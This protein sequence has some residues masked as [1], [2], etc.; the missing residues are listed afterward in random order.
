V[1]TK[2]IG[3]ILVTEEVR[4]IGTAAAVREVDLVVLAASWDPRSVTLSRNL[5]K[6]KNGLRVVF[7][8]GEGNSS[9]IANRSKVLEALS[10]VC[11][12]VLTLECDSFGIEAFWVQLT[13]HLEHLCGELGRRISV[14]VDVSCLP[15]FIPAALI[16]HPLRRGEL[17]SAL[18][19]EYA[20]AVSYSFPNGE[21]SRFAAGSW[22][23]IV[24]PGAYGRFKPDSL[25]ML[26]VSTGFD[27]SSTYKSVA[28][29]EPQR[30]VLVMPVGGSSK[31]NDERARKSSTAL[32]RIPGSSTITALAFSP[33]DVCEKLEEIDVGEFEVLLLP[34]GTKLQ[35]VGFALFVL[36]KQSPV[37]LYRRPTRHVEVHSESN[38]RS[39]ITSLV[40]T[41]AISLR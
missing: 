6:A 26:V 4:V 25:R 24:V 34:S 13:D 3:P 10:E 21:E 14:Y 2:T 19:L 33:L 12:S 38:G 28:E 39:V 18:H 16:C 7:S 17:I 29:L 22:H 9:S 31:E 36:A 27:A 11:D 30:L 20:Q 5:P 32:K 41:S 23:S 37:L 40:D 8:D 1:K 35:A 15:R